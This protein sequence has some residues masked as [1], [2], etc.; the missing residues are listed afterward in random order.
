MSFSR[1]SIGLCIVLG[2]LVAIALMAALPGCK[3]DSSKSS[4]AITY[5]QHIQPIVSQNCAVCHHPG[6]SA[7]FALLT[8]EDVKK[9]ATQIGK[10]TQSRYMP[11]WLPEH[12]Y[13]E[14][15]DERRLSDEQIQLI[16]QWVKEGAAEG[17]PSGAPTA[18]QWTEGWRLGQPDMIAEM[19]KAYTLPA[20]GK[21][22]YRNFVVPLPHETS[23]WVKAVE[24]HAG[25]KQVVHHSFIMFDVSGSAR[26]VDAKDEP[27]GYPGMDAGED[28]GT[29]GGQF[30]SWQP[31]KQPTLG[32]EARSWRLPKGADMVLQMHMRPGGKPEPIQSTVGFYFTDQPPTQYPFVLVLRSTAIDIPPGEK[33]YIIESSYTLPVDVELT[34]ILPHAHY[35][36]HELSGTATLPDGTQRPLILIKNWDFNWQGDYRYA[37]P[38]PLPKGT[39]VSMRFS[40]DNSAENVRNPSNPPK[41]VRYGLESTDEMGELWLQLVPKTR[42]ASA[43]LA[44]DY[45]KNYGVADSIARCEN[46]LKNSPNDSAL[47]TELSAALLK[48]GRGDEAQK[49][50]RRA[51][52]LDA[53]NAKAHFNLA[54][55]LFAQGKVADAMGEFETVLRLDPDHYRAHNNLGM[56]YASQGKLDQA[57]RH[58]YNAVRVN[59]NDLNA[60]MNLARLFLHQRNWGQAR[61]Q[62]QAILNIDPDNSGAKQ[63][64]A[65]VQAALEKAQ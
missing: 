23:R 37:R 43:A 45:V 36:G 61:L 10:V 4:S 31:G 50:M 27:I 1:R 2:A 62:L 35:L 8:Y 22:V 47:H 29:P 33:N 58:F 3:K 59:P 14:F 57:G 55:V 49:E 25:N 21:D 53:N 24:L 16:A 46:L 19:P 51:I 41:R 48:A 18:Q 44:Q 26:R 13:G 34:G 65:Q 64:L 39:K 60:N 40:Y 42:E 5:Q 9:H 32:N 28:V 7:P 12:G 11:P 54:N 20:D 52:E 17:K 30:L 15:A 6:E 63:L 56:I 38:M